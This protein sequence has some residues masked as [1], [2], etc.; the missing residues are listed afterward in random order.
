MMATSQSVI[1]ALLIDDH[2]LF[3]ESVSGALA[4]AGFEIAHCGSI[5]EGLRLLEEGHFD[6]VLLDYDLG[7][8][9]PRPF[10]SSVHP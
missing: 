2:A 8:S 5:Q 6:I 1:R 10:R 9:S 4:E 7:A 3:R